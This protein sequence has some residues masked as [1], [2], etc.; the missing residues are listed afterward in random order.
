MFDLQ[1]NFFNRYIYIFIWRFLRTVFQKLT[2]SL[3][4]IP[5]VLPLD[6]SSFSTQVCK[7]SLSL[8]AKNAS[9]TRMTY[10]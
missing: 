1:N 3:L 7:F 4:S 2:E 10:P 5:K 8:N 6:L 9:Y